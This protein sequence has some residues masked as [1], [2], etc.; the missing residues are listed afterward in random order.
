MKRIT[1][2]RPLTPQEAEKYRAIRQQIAEE[3]PELV[4]RHH[5][6]MAIRD[7]LQEL[8]TQL[9]AAREAKDLSLADVAELTGMDGSTISNLETGQRPNPTMEMLLQ[10]ADAVGKR[11]SIT[12]EDV[13]DEQN[14]RK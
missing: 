9:K 7:S 1:R 5:E 8:L 14:H 12:L 11:V 2:N 13:A 6:R 10:Y 4:E 3:L